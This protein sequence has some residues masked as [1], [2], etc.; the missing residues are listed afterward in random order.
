M[1]KTAKLRLRRFLLAAGKLSLSSS[2]LQIRSIML[3]A[4]CSSLTDW[5]ILLWMLV[6]AVIAAIQ[7]A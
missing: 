7:M 5:R 1:I 6:C 2:R 4:F 3:P